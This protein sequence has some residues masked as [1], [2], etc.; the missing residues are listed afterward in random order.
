MKNNKGFTLIELLGALIVMAI[1]FGIGYPIFTE[2][3]K[4][5]KDELF[6]DNV[7]NVIDAIRTVNVVEYE[8]TSGCIKDADVKGVKLTGSWELVDNTIIVHY[9]SD[10]VRSIEELS[11]D[12]LKT[13]F[14][15]SRLG[16]SETCE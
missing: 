8:Q 15:V 4:E 1:I 3:T 9:V 6:R 11:E 7:I 2:I 14:A 12:N 13:S 10:G 16:M 5:N